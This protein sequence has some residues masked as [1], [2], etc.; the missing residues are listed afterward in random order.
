MRIVIASLSA[1]LFAA[2]A[3]F[4]APPDVTAADAWARASAGAASTGAAYVALTAGGQADSLIGASTPVAQTAQVHESTAEGGI[5]RMR[6][7]PSLAIPAGKTV[8]LS[9]GGYHVMLFGLHHPLTAGQSFPLTLTFAHGGPVTV[10]V[11]VRP[12]GAAAA[13][14]DK[15]MGGMPMDHGTM[16]NMGSMPMDHGTMGKMQ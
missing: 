7:I 5:M 3:A 15:P 1:A 8:T 12:I 11:N 6:P 10:T 2:T 9:P 16:G 13:M 14:Q 4:A